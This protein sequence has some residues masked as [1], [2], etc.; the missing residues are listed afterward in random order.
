MNKWKTVGLCMALTGTLSLCAAGAVASAGETDGGYEQMV[1]GSGEEVSDTDLPLEEVV[2]NSMPAMVSIT[3]TSV[4]EVRNYFGGSGDLFD[5]FFGGYGFSPYGGYGYGG[6][7]GSMQQESVSMGSG[8]IVGESD[9]AFL[10]ATNKHVVEGAT[11]I[12]VGFIDE[13]AASAELIGDSKEEDLALIKVKKSDLSKDTIDKIKV[14]PLGSSKDLRVGQTVVAI[15]NALGYGQSASRG[16]VSALNRTITTTDNY[17][18]LET[19][20]DLI[21]T[22]AAINPG[23][24]G[25]ALLDMSGRLIGIN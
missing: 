1:L 14:I 25:G 3:N 7:G 18:Q 4:Q 21:Q 10:I 11:E 23:N 22:D 24:S 17:G 13:S 12:S 9:D 6:N 5:Y 19:S 2:E 20:D 8:V 15:G 16:I